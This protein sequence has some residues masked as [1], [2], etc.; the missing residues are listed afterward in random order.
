MELK[1]KQMQED[2][3]QV[4]VEKKEDELRSKAQQA[5]DEMLEQEQ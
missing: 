3:K 2:G 5:N 1:I 4:L